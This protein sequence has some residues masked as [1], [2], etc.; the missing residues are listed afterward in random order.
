V[1]SIAAEN[2]QKTYSSDTEKN[3]TGRRRH[4]GDRYTPT[5]SKKT[6]TD[7]E[8]VDHGDEQGG[9]SQMVKGSYDD[10]AYEPDVVTDVHDDSWIDMG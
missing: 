2:V 7:A 5:T 8:N 1:S 9:D 6:T 10:D 4:R 3:R